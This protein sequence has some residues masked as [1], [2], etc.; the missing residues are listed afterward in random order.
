[1]AKLRL[2]INGKVVKTYKGAKYTFSFKA[3]K[4]P[5]KITVQVR[6][7]DEAGNVKKSAKYTYKR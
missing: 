2:L 4:Y 3:K 5:K 6:A 7:Y 1:M